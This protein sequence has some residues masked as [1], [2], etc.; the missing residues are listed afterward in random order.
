MSSQVR[1]ENVD[2]HDPVTV[3]SITTLDNGDQERQTLVLGPGKI[4][5]LEVIPGK[6]L[7]IAEPDDAEAQEKKAAL[8]AGSEK[9]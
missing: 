9:S 8:A 4:T 1:I 3:V 2:P 7:L 6:C 5:L